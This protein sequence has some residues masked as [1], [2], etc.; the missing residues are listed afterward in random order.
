MHQDTFL[1]NATLAENIAYGKSDA[2]KS[3]IHDAAIAANLY[4]FILSLPQQF[5]TLV[6][7]RGMKLS[8]GEKQRVAIARTVLKNPPI[9]ILDEATSNVD[10]ESEQLIH[11][12]LDQL[13]NGRTAIVIAHR[14]STLRSTNRIVVLDKGQ[15]IEEGPHTQLL[16]DR[17]LY[18]R[19]WEAQ[20][21]SSVTHP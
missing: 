16:S 1:F 4:D 19:L 3:E 7:E 9:L 14:L 17:G 20:T 18:R 8:G 11:A 12:S 2:T 15:I 6:G 10:A 21:E 5:D 13:L